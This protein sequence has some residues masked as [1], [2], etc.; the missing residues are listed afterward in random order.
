MVGDSSCL[1]VKHLLI[2][3]KTV[4]SKDSKNCRLDK[5]LCCGPETVLHHVLVFGGLKLRLESYTCIAHN[6]LL[7]RVDVLY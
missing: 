6:K 3:Y 1:A 7:Y 5:S 2:I 4:H